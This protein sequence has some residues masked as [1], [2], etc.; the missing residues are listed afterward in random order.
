MGGVDGGVGESSGVGATAVIG[1]ATEME[2]HLRMKR[3]FLTRTLPLWVLTKYFLYGP[4]AVMVPYVSHNLLVGCC[5]AAWFPTSKSESLWACWLYARVGFLGL[6]LRFD[7]RLCHS[8][9]KEWRWVGRVSCTGWPNNFCAGDNPSFRQGVLRYCNNAL[10]SLFR[11]TVR[12]VQEA[13]ISFFID[14]TADSDLPL[15]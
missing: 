2:C 7:S 3:L 6:C 11:S 15:L 10:E 13:E 5:M 9:A 14:L 12:S 8:G 1:V 4:I